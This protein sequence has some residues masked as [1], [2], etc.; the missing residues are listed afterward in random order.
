MTRCIWSPSPE[1]R[2]PGTRP[3]KRRFRGRF[4]PLPG[5]KTS[6]TARPLTSPTLKSNGPGSPFCWKWRGC[7]AFRSLLFV[8]L[9]RDGA[10]IGII[11][12]SRREAGRFAPHHV[13]LL[14][15]F[16][17]QAVIAI[18]NVRLFDEV[19][20]KTR[21]LKEALHQQTATADIL[22]VIAVSP[23]DV[24]PV[25]EALV[26]TA[27]R[28]GDA[29]GGRGA[30]SRRR[31]LPP[32]PPMSR[33]RKPDAVSGWRNPRADRRSAVGR[34]AL[35][36]DRHAHVCS[37]PPARIPEMQKAARLTWRLSAP[38]CRV[39]CCARARVSA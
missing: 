34:V 17:D 36:R 9:L 21:D 29:L 7:A 8:P 12:V 3:C 27:A 15:T 6:A 38:S 1:P 2:R 23:S 35:T 30:S 25:L 5:A 11:S 22:K 24:G 20:A 39:R 37:M 33:I 14:Q 13:Q 31:R 26:E 18:E 16:A 32:V 28:A 10:T 19:Q 4:P